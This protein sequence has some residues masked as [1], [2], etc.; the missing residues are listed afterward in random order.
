MARTK[1][2]D[3]EVALQ[4]AMELFW[5]RGYETTSMAD[6]VEHLGIGRASLYATFGG[7]HELYLKA[8]RRYLETREP[9]PVETLSQPG[10]ALPAVR[11]LVES[12]TE[13]SIRDQRRRGCMIVNAAGEML[14][15]DDTVARFVDANWTA[16]ETALASALIRAQAQGELAGDRDPRAL[17]RFLL[18]FLQGL[19]LTSKGLS[20]PARLRDAAAQ[21]LTVLD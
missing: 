13:D 8:L 14:P 3:P 12:Y 20:D 5:E 2:F 21:A 4:A 1:E 9:S 15:G 10:P 6:L 17:A 16:L 7:K 11:G 18:V 19:R